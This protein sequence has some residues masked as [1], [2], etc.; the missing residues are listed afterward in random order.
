MITAVDKRARDITAAERKLERDR[1]AQEV[2]E[3]AARE[4]ATETLAAEKLE[5][6]ARADAA[7]IE[8][9]QHGEPRCEIFLGD[10]RVLTVDLSRVENLERLTA[11]EGVRRIAW[12]ASLAFANRRA[13][14]RHAG[15]VAP[16]EDFATPM[17]GST[18]GLLQAFKLG[19]VSVRDQD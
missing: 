16:L 8:L 7:E 1:R 11:I 2:R 10:G 17:L 18:A 14:T 19:L 13:A 5:R 3:R 6:A 9:R 15:A 12:S 4:V